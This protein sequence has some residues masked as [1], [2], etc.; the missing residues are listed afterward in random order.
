MPIFLI[1]VFLILLGICL[2]R[3]LRKSKSFDKIIKEVLGEEYDLEADA[4]ILQKAKAE[5]ELKAKK[6]FNEE[7]SIKLKK[8]NEKIDGYVK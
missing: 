4:L 8:E 5:E 2:F 6:K 1:V 7:V 3:F